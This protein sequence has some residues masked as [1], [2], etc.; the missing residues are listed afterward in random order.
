MC[1][2][3]IPFLLLIFV[4]CESAHSQDF[5]SLKSGPVTIR[6]EKDLKGAAISIFE[7]LPSVKN[8]IHQ[9]LTME[10]N[11]TFEIVLLKSQNLFLKLARNNN[12]SAFAIPE[13]N[14]IV[15][16]Y[17]Q[18]KMHPLH[19]KLTIMHELSHLVM[20]R[21]VEENRLPKWLDEG[22]AQWI[23]GGIYE[24]VNYGETDILRKAFLSKTLLRFSEM[25]NHFPSDKRGL[26]LAYQQSRSLIEYIEKKYGRGGL[27]TILFLLNQGNGSDH[28]IRE[29]LS[30]DMKKLEHD[31]RNSL[32]AKY[33]WLTYFSNNIYWILFV[34]CA[35]LTTYGFIKLKIRIKNYSDE[36][37]DQ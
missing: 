3:I 20:H 18:M 32:K 27:L 12:I 22:I 25:E 37:D 8:E 28:A 35:L 2:R 1:R 6:Y 10:I 23:S 19:L 13:K 7:L 34:F 24:I 11:F 5:D 29:S 26:V 21:Y 36:E 31:W 14:L 15:I 30:V 33:S 9:K 4:L 17:S 16:N